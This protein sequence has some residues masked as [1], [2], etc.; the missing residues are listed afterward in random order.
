MGDTFYLNGKEGNDKRIVWDQEHSDLIWISDFT[1]RSLGFKIKGKLR[2]STT[3]DSHWTLR[4]HDGMKVKKNQDNPN[5]P[6]D[7]YATFTP[8][9]PFKRNDSVTFHGLTSE[10]GL[11]GLTGTVVKWRPGIKRWLVHSK[12]RAPLKIKPVN[13]RLTSASGANTLGRRLSAT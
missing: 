3:L 4:A 12:N 10:V 13:L 2:L 9:G 1:K 6:L 8:A 11:N 5:Y 7:G